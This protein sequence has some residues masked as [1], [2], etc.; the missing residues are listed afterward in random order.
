MAATRRSRS[1]L[2]T[3]GHE[4]PKTGG[5]SRNRRSAIEVDDDDHIPLLLTAAAAATA[6]AYPH[7]RPSILRPATLIITLVSLLLLLILLLATRTR[8]LPPSDFIDATSSAIAL[9]LASQLTPMQIQIIHRHGDRTPITPLEDKSYWSTLLPSEKR[10]KDIAAYT[11]IIR[12]EEEEEGSSNTDHPAG[13]GDVYGRLTSDGLTMMKELGTKLR[14]DVVTRFKQRKD[15]PQLE[16]VHASTWIKVASTDF[17][18]TIQSVQSLLTGLLPNRRTVDIDIDVRHT[19]KMIPDL[20]PRRYA[21]QANRENY[22]MN[23]QAFLTKEAE[24]APLAVRLTDALFAAGV[25]GEAALQLSFGV[26][27]DGAAK[28]SGTAN[29]N[30]KQGVLPWN[31]LA[32]ILVCLEKRDRLPSEITQQDLKEVTEHN[33]WR[34]FA[35]LSDERLGTM[36]IKSL[37]KKMIQSG[38]ESVRMGSKPWSISKTPLLNIF[39]GHDATLISILCFFRIERPAVWPEYGSYLKM[40]LLRDD[41]GVL[42]KKDDD[43]SS[44]L[45]VRKEKK[46]KFRYY[47]LFSLNGE[48]LRSSFGHIKSVQTNRYFVPWHNFAREFAVKEKRL[49]RLVVQ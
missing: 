7:A 6:A 42:E 4:S 2:S 8:D 33:A 13:G 11:K 45:S 39:S 23:G 49:P 19:E 18:R 14:H 12:N 47:V 20:Q 46:K 24:M 38:E 15:V 16:S 10:L 17:S 9:Q 30:E 5:S 35:L 27:E 3:S 43:S 48:P 32:E 40:E 41:Y 31:Q 26:G 34:W 44:T 36:A 37:A 21:G 28:A 25:L 22:L 1:T 29:D